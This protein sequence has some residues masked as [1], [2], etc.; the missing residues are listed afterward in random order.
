MVIPG[1]PN[2]SEL[3]VLVSRGDMPPADS[4]RG[5]LT[6][7]EK[8]IIREWIAAGSPDVQVWPSGANTPH[9]PEHSVAP[10]SLS[11][12]DRLIRFLGKFHLLLLHFPIALLIAA[13]VGELLSLRRP[14][15]PPSV[16]SRFCLTLAAVAVIPT[17]ALGW[18]HAASGYGVG[19]AQTLSL[20][21]WLGTITGA[22]ILIAAVCV[23]R[24]ARSGRFWR[25]R[26][27][28]AVGILLVAGTAHA[29]GLLA[30]GRDFFDW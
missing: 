5:P 18:L 12:T 15:E 19:S 20:H 21:R 30:H 24:D 8:E 2:Q 28:L 14:Q 16:V 17:V 13:G 3:W 9:E 10:P 25:G 1:K 4:P 7:A 29:G 23:W 22:W 11:T 26:I 27:M 6:A